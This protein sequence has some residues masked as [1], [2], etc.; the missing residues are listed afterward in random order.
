MAVWL[1]HC[2]NHSALL[3]PALSTRALQNNE[4]FSPLS[5]AV[6]GGY[7]AVVEALLDAEADVN[8]PNSDGCEGYHAGVLARL[9][10]PA[11]Q[12]AQLAAT[13]AQRWNARH[14]NNRASA[15]LAGT[16][17]MLA[18]DKGRTELVQLLVKAGADLDSQD[19]FGWVRECI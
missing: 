19:A 9:A 15:P 16:P 18:A 4:G 8:L 13:V 6:H 10:F 11:T 2:T 5:L 17:L 3:P 1:L 12:P 14:R 7:P